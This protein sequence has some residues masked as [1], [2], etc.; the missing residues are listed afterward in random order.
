MPERLSRTRMSNA[1]AAV[2]R[3]VTIL[4]S[5]ASRKPERSSNDN[6]A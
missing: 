2:S 6:A 1:Y 3:P 5:M 4:L